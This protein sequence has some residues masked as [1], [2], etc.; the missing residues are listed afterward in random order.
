MKK[1]SEFRE[2]IFEQIL[3]SSRGIKIR[4][5]AFK[6]QRVSNKVV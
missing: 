5:K 6:Q 1:K 2:V 4:Y 3:T